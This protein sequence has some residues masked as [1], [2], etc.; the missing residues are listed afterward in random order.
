[1]EQD[2]AMKRGP[3][4][5]TYSC[6]AE[7]TG[8]E[9]TQRRWGRQPQLP[10]GK[11]WRQIQRHCHKSQPQSK[12]VSRNGSNG[13]E[14]SPNLATPPATAAAAA[15]AHQEE[16][17]KEEEQHLPL[18][19]PHLRRVSLSSSEDTTSD[20]LVRAA[21]LK[22][23]HDNE[24]EE[25]STEF[26][27]GNNV[28]VAAFMEQLAIDQVKEFFPAVRAGRIRRLLR[29]GM[30]LQDILK[31]LISQDRDIFLQL[32][33]TQVDQILE[34]FPHANTTRCQELLFE[35]KM[36]TQQVIV[37]LADEEQAKN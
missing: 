16:K 29:Q 12:V 30:E 18:R 17:E 20:H 11:K 37:L 10:M 33:Q 1:M 27:Q 22:D 6:T 36:T 7:T 8:T 32:R 31:Y 34:V 24:E 14:T 5:E 23:D 26:E 35:K 28:D 19:M 25:S 15:A 21:S 13:E 9:R 2:T 4:N 3:A